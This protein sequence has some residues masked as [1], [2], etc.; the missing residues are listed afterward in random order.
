MID[1]EVT[2]KFSIV[3]A[4]F[5]L[6]AVALCSAGAR[7]ATTINVRN[8][9]A[10]GNGSTDDTA[11][12]VRALA[13]LPS[14]GG[15]ISF[16]CGTYRIT[17]GLTLS[18]SNTRVAGAGSCTTLK[19]SGSGSF[20]A[21]TVVGR[22]L[23]SYTKLVSD[24]TSNSFTVGS[25]GLAALGITAGSYVLVSDRAIASNGPGSPPIATQQVVKIAA[26]SG[27]TAAIEGFF[28][29]NFTLVSPYPSNQGCCPY[30]QKIGPPVSTVSVTNLNID[31]AENTGSEARA[32]DF[33]FVVNSEIGYVGVS[34]FH[35]TPGPTDAIKLDTGY[36]NNFHDVVCNACGNG[37]TSNGHSIDVLRQSLATIENVRITNSAGQYSF[38]FDA[39]S[40]NYS[41][42]SNLEVDGGGAAGR[43]F[44]VL[45]SSHNTF[46]NV[47]AKNGGDNKNGISVTDVSTYNTFN[48]CAALG[49][50]GSGIKMF[51]NFNQ[52]NTFNNCTAEF[53]TSSQFSQG[54][55]SFGNYGDRYTTITGGTYCC[56]R[57][58]SSVLWI[59]SNDF[60][61]TNATVYDDDGIAPIGLSL[62]GDYLVIENNIFSRLPSGYDIYAVGANNCLLSGNHF[63]DGAH[64]APPC[65]P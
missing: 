21:L 48:N 2:R 7:A 22:G 36:Q 17:S 52:H 13:S 51:G 57:G 20:V 31:G 59:D 18:T 50:S 58:R 23:G 47:T 35:Q 32:I 43:P 29:H 28:A 46:N 5:F 19:L 61:T 64:V 3:R 30:V 49:N 15:M 9:G 44:K 26:V 14:T 60:K 1:R 53:N 45:R 33:N 37:S 16:P 40:L 25:G 27:D 62:L 8:Y 10:T 11:A 12:I 4:V 6:G 42:V 54:K 41:T 65:G 55:D 38:G 56:A 39:S 34:N 63:G 24:T